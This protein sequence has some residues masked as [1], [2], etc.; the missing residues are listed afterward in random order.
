MLRAIN[1]PGATIPGISQAILVEGGQPLYLSGHVPFDAEGAVVG[2]DH[3]T[4]LDQVFRNIADT[5]RAAGV[6]FE[7]V[8]RLTIYVRD[9]DSS[10]LPQ[11]REVRDRW[12]N[13]ACPPASA[14]VGVASLFRTDVLVEVDAFAIVPAA[15]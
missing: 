7:S 1:P 12:V 15:K 9:F 14:L 11:I 8:A 10:L 4:Q 13:T 3:A 6:G 2:A 5:L